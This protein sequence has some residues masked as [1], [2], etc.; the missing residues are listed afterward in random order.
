MEVGEE[1]EEVRCGGVVQDGR[2]AEIWR[3]G[4]DLSEESW[5][6]RETFKA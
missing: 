5:E 4:A 1:S 3:N 2:E 6:E